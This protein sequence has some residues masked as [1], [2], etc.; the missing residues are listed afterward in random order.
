M[1]LG[2]ESTLVEREMLLKRYVTSF[3]VFL[4]PQGYPK[5]DDLGTNEACQVPKALWCEWGIKTH[6]STLVGR[7]RHPRLV[8]A[9]SP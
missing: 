5:C 6:P 9:I 7:L 8:R 3:R 4:K 1:N 2:Y